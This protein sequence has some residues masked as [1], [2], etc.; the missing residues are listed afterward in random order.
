MPHLVPLPRRS[1]ERAPQM[2]GMI[3]PSERYA[4]LFEA[5]LASLPGVDHAPLR[6]WRRAAFD[7]FTALGFP[8]PKVEAWKYT[9]VRPLAREDYALATAVPVRRADL[10]PYLLDEEDAFR[11]VFVN[12]RFAAELSDDVSDLP[13]R[14]VQSLAAALESGEVSP[15]E[16]GLESS[17]ERAFSALN[18]AFAADGC[19]IR[20]DDGAELKGSVQLLFVSLG[21]D[22]P[23]LISPRNLFA[24]G[25]GARLNLVESHAAL[26][27]GRPLTNLVNRFVVG[28]GALL[29]HDRLQL[30][31]LAGSL[32]GKTHY[33]ISADARLTQSLA[34]LGGAFVR[35]EIEAVLDGSGIELGLNGLYLGRERQHIDNAIQV[36]HAR[37]GSTS[38]QFYKGVLDGRAQ[39]A[40]AGRIVVQRDAQKTNAYQAN[41]NLLL[42]ADAEI[43]TKPE[44]EIFADDV[45][46]S[47]GATAGELDERA[48]FY[49]RSRGIE[50]ATA[51]SLLT[52]AFAD[53]ALERL[54]HPAAAGLARRELLRWL[55]GGAELEG[56]L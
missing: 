42:S 1:P 23:T 8:G 41:N 33:R 14:P 55:P 45:K 39:A 30:G 32:I 18:A 5:G 36:E 20:L 12:G 46:C 7:R 53:E 44:L 34:T 9:S 52:Y 38:N 31:E 21:E 10:A 3:A 11:L 49:L 40:F 24:L 47:H 27:P 37:P 48:L 22:R 4:A 29:N 13:G 2:Q 51:R 25:A 15:F 56:L 28:P 26:G 43:D 6:E 54:H 19:V 35:N 17:T 16:L 50:P